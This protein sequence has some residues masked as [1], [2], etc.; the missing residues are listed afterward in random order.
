[1]T[2]KLNY[3][4]SFYLVSSYPELRPVLRLASLGLLENYEI[5]SNSP[6]YAIILDQNKNQLAD[7]YLSD[8]A[9]LTKSLL[10]L[11]SKIINETDKI[12][13]N[14]LDNSRNQLYLKEIDKSTIKELLRELNPATKIPLPL[15]NELGE[16]TFKWAMG[17][18]GYRKLTRGVIETFIPNLGSFSFDNSLDQSDFLA[19]I[20][21]IINA[22]QTNNLDMFLATAEKYRAK[23]TSLE[24]YNQY[25]LPKK[26][27]DRNKL[28]ELFTTFK[29]LPEYKKIPKGYGDII[30]FPIKNQL[31]EYSMWL[32]PR[33]ANGTIYYSPFYNGEYAKL[34]L[35]VYDIEDDRFL[36]M[37]AYT[38]HG[39]EVPDRIIFTQDEQNIIARLPEKGP[40][41]K[42]ISIFIS[43]LIGQP[44]ALKPANDVKSLN[45][46]LWE[47]AREISSEVQ[48]FSV[49]SNGEKILNPLFKFPKPLLK[50]VITS[51]IYAITLGGYLKIQNPKT[52]YEKE[53][54][55]KHKDEIVINFLGS[56]IIVPYDI[57][58]ATE[59]M[60]KASQDMIISEICWN[61]I[62]E[63]NENLSKNYA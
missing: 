42:G 5:L 37:W 2:A 49:L 51:S 28:T 31:M 52:S 41:M 6:A 48:P 13:I 14:L 44:I 35:Y 56:T 47:K 39:R 21:N 36:D 4:E 59:T 15:F 3:V 60:I 58:K 30:N 24:L 16:P 11:S 19:F 20:K 38:W 53:L 62:K 45:K 34:N 10:D 27:I 23:V 1:M 57:I 18:I 17:I 46:I 43:A 50:F 55:N 54:K 63:L 29:M 9:N 22:Y 40:L 8:L 61:A 26:P 7:V 25:L 32:R 12:L 33:L